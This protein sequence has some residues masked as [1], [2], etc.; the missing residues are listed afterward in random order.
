MTMTHDATAQ[1]IG[2]SDVGRRTVLKG[3]AGLAAML[4]AGVAPA[5][6]RHAGASTPRKITFVLPFLFVGG[7]AFEFVAAQEG[8]KKRGLD[9]EIL[10][11]TGSGAAAKNVA[12]GQFEFGES[13]INVSVKG[14]ADGLDIVAIAAKVQKSPIAIAC[15][16]GIKS[17]KQIEGKRLVMT[18]AGGSRILWPALVKAAGID[19]SK[20]DLVTLAPDK[21]V[22]TFL[23][24][25][26]DC[27]EVYL[28][29]NG[30][31]IQ[32]RKPDST[33][34]LYADYGLDSLDLG[35]ITTSK[36]VKEEPQLCQDFV[37]GA[38]EGLKAQ[39][40][41]PE[42]A[43]AAMRKARPEL[44]REQPEVLMQQVGSTN[45]LAISPVVEQHGL[46]YMAPRDQEQTR[47]LIL[48]YFDAKNLPPADRLFTNQFAGRVKLTAAEWARAKELAKRF[49]YTR[50]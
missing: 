5:R 21:M 41:E 40:L 4:A 34:F 12:I 33:L 47:E 29:S 26:T 35:L 16:G 50:S 19:T 45:Y 1:G 25:Q 27:S 2:A 20:I 18:A 42:R 9:V 8:W 31:T 32:V 30:A 38:M 7:H 48:K 39:L 44:E 6:I 49:A 22:S 3:A 15:R 14:V 11:G 13:S 17:L 43:L 37:D 46:G 10:R 28:V 36:R 24:G 23:G